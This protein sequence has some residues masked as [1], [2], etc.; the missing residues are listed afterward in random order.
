[1]VGELLRLVDEE[2]PSVGL[3]AHDVGEAL[4]LDAAEHV[5]QTDGEGRFHS[6]SGDVWNDTGRIGGVIMVG[7]DDA[8]APVLVSVVVVVVGSL[9]RGTSGDC[10]HR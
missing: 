2:G 9:G 8:A 4:R 5:V 7:V 1:V 10:D 6:A 3:P